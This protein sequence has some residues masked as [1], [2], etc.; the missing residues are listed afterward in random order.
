LPSPVVPSANR[1]TAS[2]AARR[3]LISALTVAVWRL[4]TEGG[5]D[6]VRLQP[7]CIA[8]V[9]RHGL[10]FTRAERPDRNGSSRL[11]SP[12]VPS[13]NR[14]TA[15]PAARRRLIS[16][17]TVVSWLDIPVLGALRPLSFVAK[18]EIAGWPVIGHL[19][20]R[21]LGEQDHGVAGGE[22]AA[23]LGVDGGGVA[24]AGAVDVI[25]HLAK[26]QRTVFIDRARRRHTA[27]VNAEMSR[28]LA[29]GDAVVLFAITGQP[30]ISD[31]ATN[32]SGRRAPRTGMSSHET[33]LARTRVGRGRLAGHLPVLLHRLFL[34][35]FGV[36]V[37]VL[38]TPPVRKAKA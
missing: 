28:R 11:P 16:A 36:R 1:T 8:Y 12:V 30:A 37:T 20:S 14:T 10:P 21:A 13:A 23:H 33:W 26:L 9:R 15:S 6:R 18:S 27:T 7:L 22:A 38:G 3:R 24:P 32:D 31:F 34:R 5:L 29:A 4:L 25:G 35:L 17:L 19:A 2:P